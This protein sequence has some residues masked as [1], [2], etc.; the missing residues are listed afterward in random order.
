ME[1]ILRPRA[2]NVRPPSSL[3]SLQVPLRVDAVGRVER[4]RVRPLPLLVPRRKD[5][6]QRH[7]H[8]AVLLGNVLQTVHPVGQAGLLPASRRAVHVVPRRPRLPPLRHEPL[9]GVQD[10]RVDGEAKVP[11]HLLLLPVCVQHG[12]RGVRMAGKDD[13]VVAVRALVRRNRDGVLSPLHLAHRRAQLDLGQA[14]GNPLHVAPRT[15]GDGQPV[16][17]CREGVEQVVVPHEA[18]EGHD[19]EGGGAGGRAGGPDGRRHGDQVVVAKGGAVALPRQVLVHALARPRMVDVPREHL[20]AAVVEA[21]DVKEH[22][23]EGGAEEVRPLGKDAGDRAAGPFEAAAVATHAKGHL[24]APPLY[25]DLA[26][27]GYEVGYFSLGAPR[28]Y[29]R[30]LCCR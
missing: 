9:V 15:A 4:M 1:P 18:H 20:G 2:A 21:D 24:G 19:G 11:Q 14:S 13:V 16:G 26:Q 7:Q 8:R 17:P 29:D 3:Q 23:V 5:G 6:I 10:G 27:E 30:S 25:P 28:T 22:V 12:Q